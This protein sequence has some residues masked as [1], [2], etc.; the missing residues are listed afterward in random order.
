[1]ILPLMFPMNG[2]H[3]FKLHHMV[4]NAV[5]FSLF[6]DQDF[7]SKNMHVVIITRKGKKIICRPGSQ[8]MLSTIHSEMNSKILFTNFKQS[9]TGEQ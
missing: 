4:L 2:N 8:Y 5:R 7:K 6:V 1:M 9:N 3:G